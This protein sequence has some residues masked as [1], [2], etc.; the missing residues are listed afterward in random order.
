MSLLNRLRKRAMT[1][2]T[3]SA[4]AYWTRALVRNRAKRG[5]WDPRMLNGQP[6]VEPHLH[7]RIMRGIAIGLVVTSTTGG[8][9]ATTS[10]HY[11]K[12]AVD[13]G[14][15]KPGTPQARAR[16]VRYQRELADKPGGLLE[17]FGPEN[18]SCVKN[19]RRI[20]LAEGTPLENLHDDHLH[21][22]A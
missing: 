5:V 11:K 10:W 18:G 16:L 2:R 1:A 13:L 9:H 15:A 4:R 14:N 22:A 6:D 3:K 20:S 7:R 8:R 12:R 19:G 17:V 21:V